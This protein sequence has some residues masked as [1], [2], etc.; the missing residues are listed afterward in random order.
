[1]ALEEQVSPPEQGEIYVFWNEALTTGY[2]SPNISPI[3]N[4]YYEVANQ[5]FPFSSE[6]E[7]ATAETKANEYLE[8]IR[9]ES[10]KRTEKMRQNM[11]G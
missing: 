5:T 6:E 9:E 7:K 3:D 8:M 1:M 10:A 2:V 4:G 11:N